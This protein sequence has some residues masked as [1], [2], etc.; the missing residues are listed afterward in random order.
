[1]KDQAH[2]VRKGEPHKTGRRDAPASE[3]EVRPEDVIPPAIPDRDGG[4]AGHGGAAE[5]GSKPV[6][7]GEQREQRIDATKH[8]QKV[9][10]R[11]DGMNDE[12]LDHELDEGIEES[13]PASDPPAIV[14]PHRP[15]DR[16]EE[17]ENGG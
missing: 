6:T 12:Q 8:G 2:D 15:P 10:D 4:A 1:M 9:P 16:D 3:P 17:H 11:E 5:R 13:F 7:A 14:S